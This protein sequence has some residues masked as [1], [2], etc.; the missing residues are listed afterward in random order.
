MLRSSAG[1]KW[2]ASYSISGAR[3]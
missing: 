1:N 2:L 3:T